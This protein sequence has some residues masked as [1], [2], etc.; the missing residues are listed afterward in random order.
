MRNMMEFHARASMSYMVVRILFL[1]GTVSLSTLM[2]SPGS[3]PHL[4]SLAFLPFT[5]TYLGDSTRGASMTSSPV[6]LGYAFLSG[7]YSYPHNTNF[8]TAADDSLTR[9]A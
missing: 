2:V 3:S 6:M 8:E 4:P 5:K 7:T 9:S 1:L